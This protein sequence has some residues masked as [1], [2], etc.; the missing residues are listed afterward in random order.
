MNGAHVF[1][2]TGTV[3]H[4]PCSCVTDHV[5]LDAKNERHVLMWMHVLS[6]SAPSRAPA[7]ARTDAVLLLYLVRTGE[8]SRGVALLRLAEPSTRYVQVTYP[9]IFNKIYLGPEEKNR[10]TV[11]PTTVVVL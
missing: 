11:D 3:A 7:A 5:G 10:Q 6:V 1:R 2:R 8:A 9:S 4:A